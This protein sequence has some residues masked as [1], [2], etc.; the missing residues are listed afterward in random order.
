MDAESHALVRTSSFTSGY[1]FLTMT[2]FLAQSIPRVPTGDFVRVVIAL[3]LFGS[4][5]LN[6]VYRSN[7]KAMLILP[8]VNL[9]FDNVEELADTGLP[10]RVPV[11]SILHKKM[12]TAPPGS[13]LSRLLPE[14]NSIYLN[15]DF[16]TTIREM[17]K[18]ELA[19]AAPR[20]V[21]RNALRDS[22]SKT[23]RCRSYVMTENLVGTNFQTFVFQ[24]R[25][26][27]KA[28]VD[29]LIVRLRESGIMDYVIKNKNANGSEC[30]KHPHSHYVNDL[31][32]LELWD[33]YGVF[34]VYAGANHITRFKHDKEGRMD[35]ESHA[36]VRTSSFTSGYIFLTMTLFLAQSIP[37]VPTED[38]VRVVIAL[39][40][41][42]SLILNTVYRSNL[43][44][45]LILPKVNLPFDNVEELADT[46]LPIRVPVRSILH[47]KMLTAPPGS[48]LSRLLPENNSIYLN[49]DFHTTIREM[50]KGELAFAAPRVVIR[51]ALRDSF[52]KTGRCRSYVMTE[53]L[54]GTNFQTFVF[55]KRSSLKA[56]VD[57]LIVRLRESGI[58]DYV[59]KNKNANGS[60]CLK[61][62]HSHYVN[63][64]RSLE[65][66]DFYGVFLVYAAGIFLG[67]LTFL[68]E[69]ACGWSQIYA[70][71]V[72]EETK[73]ERNRILFSKCAECRQ[74]S[75][76]LVVL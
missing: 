22:F 12:L 19:F 44:A 65:L 70:S 53:N 18:G 63:D 55:Q 41:F 76:Y 48:A 27:L 67:L 60:E 37:R 13:A 25:S 50:Q 43:K 9:P 24:K 34:L 74:R 20:V 40:L 73:I 52:S 61:H 35:A 26:S 7:L 3:W 47:K 36:L 33:F 56:Q 4:L 51:N 59:I 30:L 57:P 69:L 45:M 46:G 64:L 31:R 15:K 62:P 11:R 10:I 72:V 68:I 23:G 5:I 28:Q 17:Q 71:N 2:L 32:S 1:V 21:I 58:M 16:H 38:F 66:W 49:K 14:N 29:P 54:V 39:W 42:G 6:T 8:K 75:P